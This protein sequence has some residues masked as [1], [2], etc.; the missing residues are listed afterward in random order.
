[1]SLARPEQEG[2]AQK[3]RQGCGRVGRDGCLGEALPQAFCPMG[4]G[5]WSLQPLSLQ[6][7]QPHYSW[8][9][10][11]AGSESRVWGS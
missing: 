9:L 10:G 5:T 8:P 1:M 2:L 11:K 6:H 4:K 7:P 3:R